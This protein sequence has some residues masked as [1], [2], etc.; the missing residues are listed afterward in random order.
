MPKG[1]THMSDD[2]K[3]KLKKLVLK[4]GIAEKDKKLWDIFLL[5]ST[6]EENEAVYEAADS[7]EENL[8][9]LTSHL[10]DKIIHIKETNKGAWNRLAR[11]KSEYADVL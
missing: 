6:P 11:N 5:V 2:Y 3:N 8:F 1:L 7:G 10:K 4:S 9:L